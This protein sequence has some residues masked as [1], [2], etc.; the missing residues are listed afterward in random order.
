MKILFCCENYHPSVGGVQEVMRQIASRLAAEGDSVCVA[1]SNHAR[2][3]CDTVID[4]VR[5]ISF[6]V[7]G[8]AVCGFRG[9]VGDYQDLLCGGGFDAILIKAAQQWT[10]DAAVPV[11]DQ[12][13]CR[14]VFIP[15]GFSAL[16]RPEYARYYEQMPRWL[17]LFD[18]LIFYS[19]DGQDLRF[20]RD[21]PV[22]PSYLVSNGVDEREYCAAGPSGIRRLLGVPEDHQLLVTIGTRIPAKGHW[23]LLRAFRRAHL[24]RPSTLVIN[25]NVPGSS[26][27]QRALYQLKSSLRG[28]PPLG[29]MGSAVRIMQPTKSVRV[30]DLPRPEL[31]AL[32]READLFVL[33][34]RTEYAPLVLYEALAAGVPFLS[35]DVGNAR[36]IVEDT[37]AGVVLGTRVVG[38]GATAAL[39]HG[40]EEILADGAR[41]A[42]MRE[43]AYEAYG[44]GRFN[45]QSITAR[46]RTILAGTADTELSRA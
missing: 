19:R 37:G 39:A 36:E 40:M 28:F 2:R 30:V 32:L 43:A 45:W 17:G 41:L 12:V 13:P 9:P 42:R 16:G 8:N 24:C 7:K 3:P 25:A 23:E 31:V 20:A 21:F 26:P 6:A 22:G 29:L 44:S 18:A 33:A 27:R 1:T 5:V 10:F 34:S 46:Y 14:K 35:T 15:C 11:L 4:G 38:R